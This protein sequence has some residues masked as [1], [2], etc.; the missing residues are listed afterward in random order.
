[1]SGNEARL[2]CAI[3]PGRLVGFYIA[4][5]RNATSGE[6]LV[7]FRMGMPRTN[8]NFERYSVD[9][10]DLSLIISEVTPADTGEYVCVLGVNGADRAD[11]DMF[12]EQ[13]HSINITLM[14]FGM[15]VIL[16]C[17]TL[18]TFSI[19]RK[20]TFANL[21]LCSHTQRTIKKNF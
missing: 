8:A 21:S 4:T 6:V 15:S 13:T 18:K 9:P 14:V 3:Q 2:P 5:W 7:D 16:H 12:Y 10:N 20:N 1:M 17:T 19:G 11:G